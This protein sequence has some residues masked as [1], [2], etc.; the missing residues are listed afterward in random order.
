MVTGFNVLEFYLISYHIVLVMIISNLCF[1][2]L[3]SVIISPRTSRCKTYVLLF[4]YCQRRKVLSSF[5][6][7]AQF[8]DKA[9]IGKTLLSTEFSFVEGL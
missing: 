4:P 9:L 2:S 6:R 1:V 7:L 8:C 5:L 3:W